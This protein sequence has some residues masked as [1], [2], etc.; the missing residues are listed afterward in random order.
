MRESNAET[1]SGDPLPGRYTQCVAELRPSFQERDKYDQVLVVAHA[2]G[3]LDDDE[4]AARQRSVAQATTTAELDALVKDLPGPEWKADDGSTRL[5]PKSVGSP[6]ISRRGAVYCGVGFSAALALSSLIVAFKLAFG[7]SEKLPS[8]RPS[9]S[10]AEP[11]PSPTETPPSALEIIAEVYAYLKSNGY[12][13]M[14]EASLYLD[15]DPQNVLVEVPSKAREGVYD[16]VTRDGNEPVK[17]SV[18]GQTNREPRSIELLNTI[19][20][21]A[22]IA[23]SESKTDGT[24]RSAYWKCEGRLTDSE[25]TVDM[26][27]DAYG[28]GGETVTWNGD[29]T[30]IISIN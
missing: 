30:K 20:W 28:A 18:G 17:I 19:D 25:V 6:Q 5:V 2:E 27:K 10:T 16:R 11:S 7:G 13:M 12:T 29:G 15:K 21:A 22:V 23:A 9:R 1:R 8:A 4:L 24:A 3:R 26:K 14:Y